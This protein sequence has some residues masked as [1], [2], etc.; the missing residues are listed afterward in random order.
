MEDKLICNACAHKHVCLHKPM[1]YS[2]HED[3]LHKLAEAP[4][5]FKLHLRCKHFKEAKPKLSLRLLI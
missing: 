1:Y 4:V 5:P 2:T 3:F